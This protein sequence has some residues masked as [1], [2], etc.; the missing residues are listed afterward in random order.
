V[1]VFDTNTGEMIMHRATVEFNS[2]LAMA[3]VSPRGEIP[4]LALLSTTGILDILHPCDPDVPSTQVE[5]HNATTRPFSYA[6]IATSF[7]RSR[8]ATAAGPELKIW[9]FLPGGE[10]KFG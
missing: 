9:E 2:T 5:A 4:T 1:S 8:I 7:D 6:S 10:Q 3:W